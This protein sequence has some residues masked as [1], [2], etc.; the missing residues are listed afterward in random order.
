MYI[1]I[2]KDKAEAMH[3]KLRKLKTFACDIIEE[4]EEARE[5]EYEE[6]EL[7]GRERAR[8]D[9]RRKEDR[10]DYDDDYDDREMARGRG[11]RRGRG[12]Y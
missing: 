10:D 7:Y 12:R 9:G 11:G 1:I 8:R 5:K 3:E 6:D 4:L 2:K